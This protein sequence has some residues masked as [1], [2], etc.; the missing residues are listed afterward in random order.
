MLNSWAL[1]DSQPYSETM[2]IDSGTYLP[3]E[4]DEIEDTLLPKTYVGNS[5]A[6]VSGDKQWNWVGAMNN[7]AANA[8]GRSSYPAR[9]LAQ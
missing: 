7:L 5:F 6:N 2:D 3:D 8:S 9:E 4:M 1:T